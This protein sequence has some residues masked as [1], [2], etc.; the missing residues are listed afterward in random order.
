MSKNVEFASK[1]LIIHRGKILVLHKSVA[2]EG[3]WELPGGRL[4]YGETPEQTLHREVMEE[5]NLAVNII[6]VLDTW[7]SI[8][9]S[10]QIAGV[11]YLC[12]I[13]SGQLQ[14]SNEHDMYKWIN[15]DRASIDGM[16]PVFREKML[17]WNWNDIF[18]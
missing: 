2:R 7:T 13:K 5:T 17:K 15:P 18:R 3:V 16:H 12:E 14:L 10:Y 8:H 11:I 6:K 9:D 4:V 1:A